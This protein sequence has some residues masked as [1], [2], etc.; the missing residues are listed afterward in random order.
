MRL[1]MNILGFFITFMTLLP[2]N[3]VEDLLPIVKLCTLPKEYKMLFSGG[4]QLVEKKAN[5]M[6]GFS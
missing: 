6:W 2:W 4:W 1:P 5:R 3:Q